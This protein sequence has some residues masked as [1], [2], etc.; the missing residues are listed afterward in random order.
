MKKKLAII[1]GIIILILLIIPLIIYPLLFQGFSLENFQEVMEVKLGD[2][3]SIF[4]Y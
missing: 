4:R 1:L 2:Q 3:Y